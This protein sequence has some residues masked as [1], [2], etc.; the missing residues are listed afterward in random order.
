LI[1]RLIFFFFTGLRIFTMH[2]SDVTELRPSNTS[3]YLPL[4]TFRITS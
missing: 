4:P 3:L 2:F 1:S